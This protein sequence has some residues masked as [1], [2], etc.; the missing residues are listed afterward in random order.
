M[1][2]WSWSWQIKLAIPPC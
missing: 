2:S 1:P